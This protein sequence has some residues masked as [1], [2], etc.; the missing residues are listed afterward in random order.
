LGG[1]GSGTKGVI[2]PAG[3]Y[4]LCKAVVPHEHQATYSMTELTGSARMCSAGNFHSPPWI[5][6]FLLDPHTGRQLPRHGIQT[7]RFAAFDLWPRTYWG[8]TISGDQVTIDWRGGCAC[9]R[10]THII[11]PDIGRYSNLRDD[12]KI[13]C[14]KSP[15]AYA[16]AIELALSLDAVR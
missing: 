14:S 15:D 9:G 5:V 10:T 3:W 12:D 13:S 6:T 7:G 2:Y 4:E 11:G 8:G 1:Q 16:K